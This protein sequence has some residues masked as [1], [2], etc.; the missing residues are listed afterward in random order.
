[1][2]LR[3]AKTRTAKHIIAL[4]FLLVVSARGQLVITADH[5]DGI[6]HCGDRVTWS[7]EC[8]GDALFSSANFTV[9]SG[10]LTPVS[11]GS[12]SLSA[13]GAKVEATLQAPGTLLL[14]VDAKQADGKSIKALGGAVADPDKIQPS[15]RRP[16]DFDQFWSQKIEELTAIPTN[17]QLHAAPADKQ[18]VDYW[19]ITLDNIR[20]THVHGQLARPAGTEKLPALLIVQWA[21]VYGL[22]KTWVTDRAAE[23]WLCLDIEAHDLPIDQSE[24][25]YKEQFAGPLNEYWAIGNDDRERSY[26][27]RMYLSCYQA[28]RYLTERDDWDGT[29]LVVMGGSQGGLQALMTAAIH[30]KI[31]AALAIVP[32]GCDMLGPDV[33]RKGGWP[34]W[35][36]K[37]QG[38]DAAKVRECSRYFD[39]VNFAPRITCPVLVGLGL[40]DEV[41]PPEGILAAIN[42]I[43]SPHEVNILPHANHQEEHQSHAAYTKRCWE[44]WLPALRTGRSPIPS[45]P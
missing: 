1:M 44:Q 41:C 32:A 40:I 8:N 39:V 7:I 4:L 15:A 34:Q 13:G 6:Y 18:G 21:G 9:T 36:D 25:F 19:K 43:H 35:F 31:T 24:T 23:G 14:Q 3:D 28:A 2:G 22:Q 33:G 37:I 42:Q 5:A 17:P 10:E 38:K 20:D 29:T 30:P 11:H 16:A 12:L 26:F 45:K 27:L